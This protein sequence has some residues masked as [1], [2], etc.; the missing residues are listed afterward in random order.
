M[1]AR[2]RLIEVNN[3]IESNVRQAAPPVLAPSLIFSMDLYTYAI[4]LRC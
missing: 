1:S 2:Q 4:S 3:R